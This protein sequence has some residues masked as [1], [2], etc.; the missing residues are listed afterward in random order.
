MRVIGQTPNLA[1]PTGL[2]AVQFKF[3][4]AAS[5]R[6]GAKTVDRRFDTQ[7]NSHLFLIWLS[8]AKGLVGPAR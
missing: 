3:T 6:S 2:M 4:D 5:P 7:Q 8:G 1:P